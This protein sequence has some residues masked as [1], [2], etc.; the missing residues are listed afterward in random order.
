MEEMV[1][2]FLW[3]K[4]K[5]KY[6]FPQ[7]EDNT[8]KLAEHC[9]YFHQLLHTR[10]A[11]WNAALRAS[12]DGANRMRDRL[13]EEWGLLLR[14]EA[15]SLRNDETIGCFGED[16]LVFANLHHGLGNGS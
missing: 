7:A 13:L 1:A 10:A 3:K 5:L 2:N 12:H 16:V 11:W 14:L 9:D 15:A 6:M 8:R 4:E